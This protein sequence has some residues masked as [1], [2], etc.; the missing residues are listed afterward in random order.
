MLTTPG[1]PKRASRQQQTGR[2]D[3]GGDLPERHLAN[4]EP[5]RERRGRGQDG[6]D[7]I[8]HADPADLAGSRMAA[9]HIQE[10]SGADRVM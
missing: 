2:G 3:S 5:G 4:A 6:G 1:R 8:T 7:G 10:Y 9:L